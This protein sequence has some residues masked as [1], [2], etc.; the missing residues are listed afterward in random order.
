MSGALDGVSDCL[1]GDGRIPGIRAGADDVE[2]QDDHG[3]RGE[4]ALGLLFDIPGHLRVGESEA[5]VL[6]EL[7]LRH[8]DERAGTLP[9]SA[10][11]VHTA[12]GDAAGVGK[13]RNNHHAVGGFAAD[14]GNGGGDDVRFQ[15]VVAAEGR[16]A[17]A[18]ET[19]PERRG[20]GR[21]SQGVADDFL[22]AGGSLRR[23]KAARV[24]QHVDGGL[25]LGEGPPKVRHFPAGQHGQVRHGLRPRG[26][27][28]E[29]Y[30]DARGCLGRGRHAVRHEPGGNLYFRREGGQHVCFEGHY[31]LHCVGIYRRK[32]AAL[33]GTAARDQN[34]RC[35]TSYIRC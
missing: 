5:R 22:V 13:C 29:H 14:G 9:G 3:V 16:I 17:A 6:G 27:I 4:A 12:D 8:R 18:D 24:G 19:E 28:V 25:A 30:Q 21:G 10:H 26:V 34:V 35:Q 11:V 1:G 32:A 31:S 20:G 33:L 2:V 7:G 15:R 23:V